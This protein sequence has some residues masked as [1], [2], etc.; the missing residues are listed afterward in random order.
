MQPFL[1]R[2]VLWCL[3]WGPDRRMS[4]LMEKN[5]SAH[6][7]RN[8]KTALMFIISLGFIIFAGASFSL[9]AATVGNSLRIFIGADGNVFAPSWSSPLPEADFRSVLEAELQRNG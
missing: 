4:S 8:E 9:Q 7:S 6:R 3:V 1:E 5:L 2:V